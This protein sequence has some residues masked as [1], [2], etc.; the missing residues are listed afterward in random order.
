MSDI[1]Y[2]HM[3]HAFNYR[4]TNIQAAFLYDQLSQVTHILSRKKKIFD[5]YS[6]LLKELIE[7]GHV[8]LFSLEENT[9]Q[10]YWIFAIRLIDNPYTINETN[11]FF[12]Q[13]DID[14]RPF[15]YP[16]QSH[17]HLNKIKNT[18][19]ISQMI[20]REIIMIPSSPTISLEQQIKVV[21]T[22]QLFIKSYKKRFNTV[23]IFP[24]GSGVAKEIFDAL[25]Y[26]RDVNLI[27]G[28]G[29]E[30]NFTSFLFQHT[31]FGIPH[32]NKEHELIDRLNTIIDTYQV[33]FIYPAY[34]KVHWFL[35]NNRD[36]INCPIIISS[37]QTCDICMSKSKTYELLKD[38]IPVPIR[39]T[40][41]DPSLIVYPCFLKPDD[42]CGSR[43]SYILENEDDY[44]YYTKKIKNAI[45]CEYLPSEEFTIDCFTNKRGE[46][47]F[48]QGR[49][50][51]KTVSGM[52]IYTIEPNIDFTQYAESINKVLSFNGAWFFQMKY[53]INGQLKLLEVA[54]RIAGAMSHYR[55]KGINFPLITLRQ[56]QG[57][58]INN[59]LYNHSIQIECY[60]V[61]ENKFKS[62]VSYK[63]AFIDLDDTLI[64]KNK[65][66]L[67]MMRFL[68]DARNKG[69]ILILLTRNPSSC[70]VLDKYKIHTNLFEQIIYV[71]PTMCKCD[72][73]TP[74]SIFIDDSFKERSDVYNKYPDTPV[75]G[76]DM[77]ESLLTSK[78]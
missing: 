17:G 42:G 50:R 8:K 55:N 75:Y 69:I 46:L 76:I 77:V 52:S 64:I 25:K 53:D 47:L 3:V 44:R 16:I 9:E 58:D 59:V 39:M 51:K 31:E 66:N 60:K 74:E 72:F 2:V 1:R 71:S 19:N 34:D 70:T 49:M 18:D 61:Y 78:H 28:D 36:R 73:I 13:H 30:E 26:I 32:I 67:E 20:N 57:Q 33:D 22:I 15:F 14:I 40:E 35:S 10:T 45:I 56:F 54:P 29:P 6:S 11:Y 23:L 65:V 5:T 24:S 4:M 27:G 63:T 7:L 48:S 43:N 21:D 12:E 62:N 37:H 68:Y 38:I 41:T